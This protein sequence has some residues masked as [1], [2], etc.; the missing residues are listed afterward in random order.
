M[1]RDG[2][3]WRCW[4]CRS[5]APNSGKERPASGHGER[6]DGEKVIDRQ[7]TETAEVRSAPCQPVP[8]LRPQPRLHAEIRR[9]PYLL[10]RVGVGRALARRH[11][12]EL[13]AGIRHAETIRTR[14][15]VR[16]KR[17]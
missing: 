15:G 16:E 13:V 8:P 14:S 7:I 4:A 12:V 11:Q 5:P 2:G 9:L 1:K 3:S 6:T 10:P 17:E